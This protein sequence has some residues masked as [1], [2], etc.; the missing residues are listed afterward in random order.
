M[1]KRTFLRGI[2]LLPGVFLLNFLAC[3]SA[4]N[5]QAQPLLIA[6]PDDSSRKV[7]YFLQKPAGLGPWPTVIFLHG[8]QDLPRRG[9]KDFVNWGVLDQFAKRG[10]LAV[11]ISQPGYGNSSGPPDFCGAFTQHAVSGVIARLRADG[12]VSSNKLII[13]GISRGALVA[14]L[15]AAHDT[16]VAGIVLISGLYDLPQFIAD[17]NPGQMKKSIMDS[18]LQE[19][20]GGEDALKSRS[21]LYFAKDI[22]AATLI[23]NGEKDD[24]TDPN[25]ARRLAKEITR[26]GGDARAIIYPDYGHQI[27]VDERNKEIDP[28]IERVL[29][30]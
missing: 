7:E 1:R 3:S 5:V 29:G 16:S 22:K 6:H 8:H 23:I 24:R 13:E 18:L 4:M 20:G 11:A 17:S 19:T 25:Q 28:F 30:K 2:S 14:G 21:V 9:A 15:V 10:F 27:P 12:Y 26:N